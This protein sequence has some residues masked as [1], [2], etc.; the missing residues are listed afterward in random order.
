MLAYFG[1]ENDL[2]INTLALVLRLA[3][4]VVIFPHG[5]QKLLGWYGGYG[6]KGTMGYFTQT[7]HI[8]YIFGLLAIIAE[9][10]GAL[11]VIA[12]FLTP[13]AAFGIGVTMLVAAYTVHRPNG[14]FMNWFGNQVGEGYEYFILAIGAAVALTLIGGGEWSLDH[15]LF[16]R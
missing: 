5:A 4:G 8:P 9:F 2:L 1:S 11:A 3:L 12:G 15:V 6:F 10:F 7:Q 14:F 16:S 13:I